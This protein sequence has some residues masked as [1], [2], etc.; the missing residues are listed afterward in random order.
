MRCLPLPSSRCS[1]V[2]LVQLQS[3]SAAGELPALPGLQYLYYGGKCMEWGMVGWVM[4]AGQV[5]EEA[6]R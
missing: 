3:L 5:R 1:Y 6:C 4:E 2:V